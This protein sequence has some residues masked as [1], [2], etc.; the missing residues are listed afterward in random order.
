MR[1]SPG[2]KVVLVTGHR[3]Y[4]GSVLT[5]VL[6]KAGHEVIGLDT[7]LYRECTFGDAPVEVPAIFKDIRDLDGEDLR[8][9]DAVIHLAGL[10]GDGP[11]DLD[12][13]LTME[14]N[15]TASVRLASLAREADVKRFLFASSCTVYGSSGKR[16][17]DET[18]P[19]RPTTSYAESKARAERDISHMFDSSFA[20]IFLR[21]AEAYG[22]SPRLRCDLML[23][24]LVARAYVSGR[25]ILW[26]DS[27]AWRTVVH[28]TD[29]CRAFLAVLEGPLGLVRNQ[30]FNVGRHGESYRVRELAGIAAETVVDAGLRVARKPAPD[31]QSHRANCEKIVR[32]LKAYRPQWTAR[33]G[34]AQLL[35]AFRSRSLE[36]GALG[37]ARFDRAGWLVHLR[38]KGV[39]DRSLR[40]LKP[41]RRG[42]FSEGIFRSNRR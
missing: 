21:L 12:H 3:G 29:V 27:E 37:G 35:A 24:G 41:D 22:L 40:F 36:A 7:D 31:R 2:N 20:P 4:I 39:V 19:L 33:I 11:A 30:V 9:F 42:G 16:P 14:I 26:S 18:S 13:G 1:Q 6:L 17:C 28:V 5:P 25:I 8:G 10:S 34:A 23:N 15:H 38:K 32:V